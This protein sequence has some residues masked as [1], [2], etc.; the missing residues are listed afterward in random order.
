MRQRQFFGVVGGAAAAAWPF[1]AR[2]KQRP[3]SRPS[4]TWASLCI[5]MTNGTRLCTTAE[6]IGSSA[7]LS[8]SWAAS[9][10]ACRRRSTFA[11]TPSP[12]GCQPCPPI[13]SFGSSQSPMESSGSRPSYFL[14]R[15]HP[16]QFFKIE[17]LMLVE[18]GG[19][20]MFASI[21]PDLKT[22]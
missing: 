14:P 2:A 16:A 12:P 13:C 15:H 11:L 17:A 4:G 7:G 19:P 5:H 20:T 10:T 21:E 3:R 18:C 22:A 1:A 9:P 6:T 8:G